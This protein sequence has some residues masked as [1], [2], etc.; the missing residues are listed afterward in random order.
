MKKY[1]LSIAIVF[2]FFLGIETTCAIENHKNEENSENLYTLTLSGEYDYDII[3]EVLTL[4]NANRKKAGLN[5]LKL[6][7]TLTEIAMTRARETSVYWSHTR[8]NGNSWSTLVTHYT[9]YV[10]ENIAVNYINPKDVMIGWME[11]KG[12]R[13]NILN[14]RWNS[15][16]IGYYRIGNNILWVQIF[17]DK[18]TVTTVEKKG[19]IKETDGTVETL[20]NYIDFRVLWED[21]SISVK[22]DEQISPKG[23]EFINNGYDKIVIPTAKEDYIWKSSD[24]NIFT[25]DE[26][27]NIYGKKVG[28]AILSVS[29][30]NV[31]KKYPVS[32]RADLKSISLLDAI[33]LSIGNTKKLSVVYY[34]ENATLPVN[35]EV[36]WTSS[37]PE[38]ATVK[39]GKVVAV[40]PGTATI[41]A[42]LGNKNAST[43]VTVLPAV[44]GDTDGDNVIGIRDLVNFFHTT[45][46][47]MT[48]VNDL[49]TLDI[50]KNGYIDI[51][52][53]F[54]MMY[55]GYINK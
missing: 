24:T 18:K 25:V 7:N 28:D 46:R 39:D 33:S 13:D 4:V 55:N 16:G 30:G 41:M 15:I 21:N 17:S 40:G 51:M 12:H 11:S 32:V 6:D 5:T 23:V 8:P 31:E 2:T 20:N 27:G 14:S 42:T 49:M 3:N 34:P 29:I 9:G 52:D 38:V 53:I 45:S 43:K 50:N 22:M 44:L 1:L 35:S 36:I 26:N 47:S 54:Y 19:N 10:G 48:S 37:N